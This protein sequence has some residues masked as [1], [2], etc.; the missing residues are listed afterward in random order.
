MAE[1]EICGRVKYNGDGP[2]PRCWR[3][4]PDVGDRHCHR[5]GYEKQKARA[6]AAERNALVAADEMADYRRGAEITLARADR[7]EAALRLAKYK[8]AKE[9]KG[10]K[11]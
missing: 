8:K 3:E 5:L 1:C 11:I 6:E 10:A 4:A 7:L 2:P 9:E